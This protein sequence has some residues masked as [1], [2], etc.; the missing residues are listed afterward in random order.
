MIW[1]T[2]YEGKAP[3]RWKSNEECVLRFDSSS[4][5]VHHCSGFEDWAYA[6][7][8]DPDR[9]LACQPTT[10]N[11]YDAAKTKYN[12]STL[13]V[14]NMLVETSNQKEPADNTLGTSQD[15][16]NADTA[17]NGHVS[18]NIRLSLLAVDA[19][20][21]YVA[22]VG[23]NELTLTDDVVP[24]RVE[25]DRSC[26]TTKAVMVP[27]NQHVTIRWT[28]GGVFDID[29]TDVWYAKWDS[30]PEEILNCVDPPNKEDLL[31]YFTSAPLVG[32]STGRGFFHHDGYAPSPE[33]G[34]R[35]EALG[36]VFSAT[37]DVRT[38]QTHDKLVVVATALVDQNW[39]TQKADTFEPRLPPQ[40]H[41]VNART[42]PDWRHELDDGKIVQGRLNWVSTPLTIVVGDYDDSVG[43]Q[44][45]RQVGTV[46]MS[47]RFGETTGDFHAGMTPAASG[48]SK[49]GS[50]IV[51]ILGVMV[52]VACSFLVYKGF[53]SS[54]SKWEKRE[55]YNDVYQDD[56]DD[57]EY[58]IARG[59]SDKPK[60]LELKALP[61][62]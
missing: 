36:P 16:F 2:M 58:G 34:T 61:N 17:G 21:P 38:F 50:S 31:K 44:S 25:Q 13:R 20:Q 55:D 29:N 1:C 37:M 4:V 51:P 32:P 52:V 39:K 57:D 12:N 9:V 60:E 56:E 28:V 48:N 10:F 27:G 43:T 15:V 26:Q 45:G 59:Y 3:S 46:E 14:F 22:M 40:S 47:N 5:V 18:R 30:V 33:E 23:V 54:G 41:I 11:G 8:W 35:R 42:N 53:C 7:S 24:L 62:Q 49:G 6:G 19:V